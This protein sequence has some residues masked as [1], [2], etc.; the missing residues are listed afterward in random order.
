M[1]QHA[2]L[3]IIGLGGAFDARYGVGVSIWGPR[4][5]IKKPR[6]RYFQASTCRLNAQPSTR[7]CHAACARP[8]RVFA[9]LS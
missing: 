8:V 6:L 2:L 1:R 9:F 4:I 7:V 5:A 3:L